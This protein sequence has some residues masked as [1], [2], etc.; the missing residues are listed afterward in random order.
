M[1]AEVRSKNDLTEPA[2]L[3]MSGNATYP[4]VCAA[5]ISCER[6]ERTVSQNPVALGRSSLLIARDSFV[7][8]D[9][10]YDA[11]VFRLAVGCLVSAYLTALA[12]GTGG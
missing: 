10:D 8:K 5:D 2:L 9:S 11:S 4:G 1:S 7:L 12:H 6:R 3:E